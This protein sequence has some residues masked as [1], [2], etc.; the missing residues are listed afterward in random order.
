MTYRN[1]ILLVLTVKVDVFFYVK[2][3]FLISPVA[4]VQTHLCTFLK[5]KMIYNVNSQEK[6]PIF[7]KKKK[8]HPEYSCKW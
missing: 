2:L 5:G 1:E 7:K 8:K 3:L 6:K 4:Y